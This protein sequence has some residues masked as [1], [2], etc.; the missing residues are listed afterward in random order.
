MISFGNLLT[1][2]LF[3]AGLAA[4]K[5]FMSQH[6]PHHGITDFSRAESFELSNELLSEIGSMAPAFPTPMRR[7][8]VASAPAA[9]VCAR[10]VQ[11]L[12]SGFSAPIEVVATTDAA[13]ASLGMNGSDLIDVP[14]SYP[15]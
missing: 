15:L 14:A 2:D 5:D 9:Y 12:R 8:V 7:T 10:I 1:D 4:A 6:G 3:L 11:T 13:Y